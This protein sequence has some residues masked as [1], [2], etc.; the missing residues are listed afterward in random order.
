MEKLIEFL[1]AVRE[2]HYD[3]RY[4]KPTEEKYLDC[5]NEKENSC[6]YVAIKTCRQRCENC[7]QVRRNEKISGG[8]ATNYEILSATMVGRRK[9]IC[10]SNCLKRLKKRN[11][12]TRK[13]M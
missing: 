6:D 9:K 12:C 11:I 8:W 2:F 10:I 13:A 3:Q 4:Q 1:T 7:R 5:A